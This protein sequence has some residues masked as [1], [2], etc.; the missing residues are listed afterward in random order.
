MFFYEIQVEGTVFRLHRYFFERESQYFR[1]QLAP[2]STRTEA[3]NDAP[4]IINIQDV[5]IEE[6]ALFAWVFYNP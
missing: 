3:S 1:D 6:F 4:C 2:S 5:K